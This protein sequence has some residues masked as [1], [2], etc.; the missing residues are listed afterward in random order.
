MDFTSSFTYL[1]LQETFWC[2]FPGCECIKSILIECGFDNKF[3]LCNID[4]ASIQMIEKHIQENPNII[5]NLKCNHKEQYE[6]QSNMKFLPGHNALLLNIKEHIKSQDDK[7]EYKMD[8]CS[9]VLKSMVL[10]ADDNYQ[11]EPNR[12]RFPKLLMDF[13]IYTYLS[14]GKSCYKMLAENLPLPKVP[15]ICELYH[16]YLES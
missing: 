5:Q 7:T 16:L 4:E 10:T 8:G 6:K 15:T 11:K 2:D 13:G 14:C 1:I 9:T 3:S 12:R